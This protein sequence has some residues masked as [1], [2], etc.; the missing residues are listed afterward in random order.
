M[1]KTQTPHRGLTIRKLADMSSGERLRRFDEE[2]GESY[3]LNPQTGR[4]EGWPLLGIVPEGDLPAHAIIPTSF[5]ELG[6]KDGWIR[7]EGSRSVTRPGGPEHDPWRI[8]RDKGIPH[9]FRH[10]DVI[11]LGF[12][13]GDVRYVVTDQPD[14]YHD[15]PAGEDRAGDQLAEVRHFYLADLED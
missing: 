7:V 13:T 10:V 2:T 3:L 15:G 12:T 6:I 1:A 8:D 14:K 9:V 4:R 11:V 5:V